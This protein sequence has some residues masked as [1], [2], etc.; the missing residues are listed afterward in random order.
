MER[1]L[2]TKIE[3][4]LLK[5][6]DRA[7]PRYT[8]YPTAVEFHENVSAVEYEDRLRNLGQGHELSLYL[9]L[10]FCD[11]RCTFCG[12]HVIATH[13]RDVAAEYLEYVACELDLVCAHLASRPQVVQYHWGGGTPTFYSP[14][15]LRQL[16]DI[17][18]S[19]FDIG[20]GAEMAVE[21]DPRVTSHEH[22]DALVELGFNRI[23]M[24]VQDFDATVQEVIG[25]RQD[26]I[27]TRELFEYCSRRPI[28][29]INFDLI[30]GLP[31]QTRDS[32]AKTLDTVTELRPD[33]LA[34]YSYAHVPWIK[35]HQKS[36][37]TDLLPAPEIKTEMF[38]SAITT[39]ESA[40][41][42]YIG[43][44]HFALPT[45]EL[46]QALHER[47]LHRNFMGY[48]VNRSPTM[49]GI[50][51]SAIG[52]CGGAFLQNQK[53]LSTYYRDLDAGRLPVEKGYELSADDRIRRHVILSLMCNR[54]LDIG[55]VEA[56]Y[57]VDFWQYFAAEVTAL[58]AG[59]AADNLIQIRDAAIEVTPTGRL[60][61]RNVC[62]VFDR[63][64]QEKPRAQP[65]FSRTV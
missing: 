52:E 53:K 61:V 40:G 5:K 34:L 57:D 29:S 58:E 3:T 47:R 48:T 20:S 28:E 12:C 49:I 35:G 33:R 64:L 54:Y 37:D 18:L 23:S 38:T 16:H 50:G 4:E 9:H 8:S 27:S 44:D 30:Y 39:F 14:G 59:P 31:G 43:I 55:E 22:I 15:Q 41:Y 45:D 11:H 42:E 10:P 25:R 17:V 46:S 24:G 19:H 62:M 21:V 2:D 60:F 63:H 26:E 7:G 56:V 51:I 32:F 1:T 36:I 13:R 6:Y 65:T